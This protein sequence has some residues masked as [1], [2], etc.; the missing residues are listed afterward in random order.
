MTERIRTA[1]RRA[2]DVPL[3]VEDYDAIARAAA[4]RSRNKRLRRAAAGAVAVAIVVVAAPTVLSAGPDGPPAPVAAKR[5]PSD[6]AV[7]GNAVRMPGLRSGDLIRFPL[8]F[9]DGSAAELTVPAGAGLDTMPVRPYG[10]ARLPGVADRD[11]IVPAGGLA[12]FARQGTRSRELARTSGKT[13]SLWSIAKPDGGPTSYLV[14]EF[15]QWVVG[16]WDGAGG[17]H[18]SEAERQL[19]ADNLDGRVTPDRLLV[20]QAKAPLE[21]LGAESGAPPTLTWGDTAGTGLTV[22]LAPC[23]APVDDASGSGADRYRVLCRPEW[24]AHVEISGTGA[25]VDA[26]GAAVSVRRGP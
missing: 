6:T 21:L 23:A 5:S 3:R 7:D 4:R 9:I 1:L 22:R 15:G 11:F 19:W 10:G 8:T 17:A 26:V 16:V 25:Y 18:L 20:L 12:W 2:A 13:V 24:G 14:Y